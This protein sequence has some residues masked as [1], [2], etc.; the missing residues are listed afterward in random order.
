MAHSLSVRARKAGKGRWEGVCEAVLPDTPAA[1]AFDIL[2]CP[3]NAAN[4][5]RSVRSSA[6]VDDGPEP[7]ERGPQWKTIRQVWNLGFVPMRGAGSALLAFRSD[8]DTRSVEYQMIKSPL[9]RD[10]ND[11]WIVSAAPGGGTK[12]RRKVSTHPR[13][14]NPPFMSM[15][16]ILTRSMKETL[17][18]FAAEASK[19]IMLASADGTLSAVADAGPHRIGPHRRDE[20]PIRGHCGAI[21]LPALA[22]LEPLSGTEPPL[23]AGLHAPPLD[24]TA[25]VGSGCSDWSDVDKAGL[26]QDDSTSE[27]SEQ[28]TDRSD[29]TTAS[30]DITLEQAFDLRNLELRQAKLFSYELPQDTDWGSLPASP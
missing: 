28:L 7:E 3:L 30:G 24:L 27:G 22:R 26:M 2:K 11:T 29:A 19:R 1:L 6:V 10:L 5:F 25:D 23:V 8:A 21:H 13:F 4:V 18:D 14:P 15:E 12:I 17:D 16:G 20:V 9:F